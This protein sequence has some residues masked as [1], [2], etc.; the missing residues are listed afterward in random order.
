MSW[1]KHKPN[2]VHRVSDWFIEYKCHCGKFHNKE[3]TFCKYCGCVINSEYPITTG[4][5]RMEWD[6][7]T[8]KDRRHMEYHSYPWEYSNCSNVKVVEKPEGCQIGK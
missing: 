7:D 6:L 4:I 8:A 3:V 1:F 2:L 5:V